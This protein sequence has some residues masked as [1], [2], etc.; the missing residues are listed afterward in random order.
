[1]LSCYVC[2]A[3]T[4]AKPI[5]HYLVTMERYDMVRAM[6]SSAT[7]LHT[8]FNSDTF[9]PGWI[10]MKDDE[11]RTILHITAQQKN[12]FEDLRTHLDLLLVQYQL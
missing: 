11:G 1:M 3:L 12:E 4:S 5:L 10:N 2:G 6:L 7:E 9:L 8:E